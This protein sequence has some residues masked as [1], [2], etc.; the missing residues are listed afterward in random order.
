LSLVLSIPLGLGVLT[1]A[2]LGVAAAGA[3]ALLAA[4]LADFGGAAPPRDLDVERRHE[5]RLYLGA[6]NPIELVVRNRGR[7]AV[8][9][10][11]RDTPPTAFQSSAIFANGSV[12]PASVGSFHYTTRPLER[13][14]YRFGPLVLRWRSP[15]GLLWRQR[16]Y[17]LGEEVAVYPNL[18]EVQKYDLLARKGLLQEMGLR[19][20]RYL[21]RGTEF[22]SLRDYRRGDEYRRINWKATAR[23]HRPITAQYETERNQRLILMLDL[24]RMMLTRVAGMTRLDAA[25]NTALLLAY[26]ALA[27]GDR[28]GLLAFDETVRA[29]ARPGRGRPHFYHLVEQLYAIR[30]RPIEP[31]YAAAFTRLR[32]DLRGR[33]LI[34]LFT[35]LAD[36]DSAR[37]IAS[38]LASLARH[39]LPMCVALADPSLDERARLVPA[40][41][42]EV[43]EK[44]VAALRS[45][46]RVAILDALRHAGVLTVD[47]PLDRLTPATINRYL[48]LKERALL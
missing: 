39:H 38:H 20:T 35:D 23:R 25:V 4:T 15:L 48:E 36:P 27:H 32:G 22:E 6:D 34:A 7:R 33:A 40:S 21:G 47:A 2:F 43:Y 28:V 24:G 18:R 13:G 41:G 11:L 9:V 12:A 16:T 45:D 17:P 30:A 44:V 5:P 42:R 14:T 19:S 8:G 37:V 26:V 3:L 10:R 46:E 29:Y 1:P 31:D